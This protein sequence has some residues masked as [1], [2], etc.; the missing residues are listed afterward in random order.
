MG[1]WRGKSPPTA[2]WLGAVGILTQTLLFREL[3]N[4]LRANELILG[5]LL[6]VWLV[7]AGLGGLFRPKKFGAFGSIV[8]V[9]AVSAV[10][11]PWLYLWARV[12]SPGVGQVWPLP[13]T[14]LLIA[15]AVFPQAFC[16]GSAFSALSERRRLGAD[17]SHTYIF[18]GL[19]SFFGGAMSLVLAST[20]R[21]DIALPVFSAIALVAVNPR[22]IGAR[23]SVK[24]LIAVVVLAVMPSLVMFVSS[25]A[26]ALKGASSL[27]RIE[28]KFG[29]IEISES[30]GEIYLYQ[31]GTS[32][33]SDGDS[34][35]SQDVIHPLLL[36]AKQSPRVAL[37]G[38]IV[39]GTARIA[40]DY[41]PESLFVAIEDPRLLEVG[42]ANF[43]NFRVL[44]EPSVRVA[45]GDPRRTIARAPKSLDLVLIYT[46]LPSSAGESRLVGDRMFDELARKISPEGRVAVS[47]P[48]S[49][50][51]LT[52]EE[53][54]LVGSVLGSAR[55]VFG[56]AEFYIIENSALVIAPDDGA[57]GERITAGDFPEPRSVTLNR[58]MVQSSIEEFRQRDIRERLSTADFPPNTDKRPIA[59]LIGLRL[60]ERLAGG[61]LVGALSAPPFAFWMIFFIAVFAVV[62]VAG[63][64][65]RADVF[66]M[67]FAISAMGFFGMGA[68]VVL[69]YGFQV[70]VGRLYS[71]V[72][73]LSSMFILGTV[74]GAK[75]FSNPQRSPLLWRIFA[76]ATIPVLFGAI[77]L[78][79]AVPSI[80]LAMALFGVAMLCSGFA[81]G[82][83]YSLAL[84]WSFTSGVWAHKAPARAY[85]FDLIGASVAGS[86]V[87]V[88][89]IPSFGIERTLSLLIIF[90]IFALMKISK[91]KRRNDGQYE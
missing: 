21:P 61:F 46:G 52:Q 3:S 91:T 36:T 59:Y 44:D 32:L 47:M 73:L 34:L 2:F 87:G 79:T 83:F 86:I 48:V 76:I 12:L 24:I 64:A 5:L 65:F 84:R 56:T 41:R 14:F 77:E 23:R 31:G 78:G 20:A 39:Q 69:L 33:G 74:F 6:S 19:G 54:A 43:A 1:L 37:V 45:L 17:S 38:G 82:G 13:P 70:A 7:S 10:S 35:A 68:S 22:E 58:A 27:E 89:F 57:F 4:I 62:A 80:S 53:L 60:W 81:C 75:I 66:A 8:A 49:P 71:A 50:N 51:Y 85:A 15:L 40:L 11:V 29:A 67:G 42:W 9:F 30:L 55:N 25:T 63:K 72:G 26:G 90:A 28:S 18:E 16:I 88:I